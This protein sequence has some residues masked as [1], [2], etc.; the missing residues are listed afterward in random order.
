MF[1]YLS[2]GK[3]PGREQ[4]VVFTTTLESMTYRSA[5]AKLRQIMYLRA[6]RLTELTEVFFREVSLE[7]NGVSG[8][9]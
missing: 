3:W 4:K 7:S 5:P 1:T 9:V 8:L 6:H 2:N